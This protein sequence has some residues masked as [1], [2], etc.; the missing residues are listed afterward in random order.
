MEK[1]VTKK[2]HTNKEKLMLLYKRNILVSSKER[3]KSKFIK[4]IEII[5]LP[6]PNKS[7][8]GNCI[9]TRTA[10]SLQ[11]LIY[12]VFISSQQS[13]PNAPLRPYVLDQ[14][15]LHKQLHEQQ[16]N[17]GAHMILITL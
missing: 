4:I 17:K 3:E 14:R 11:P 16:G 5:P 2:L 6:K 1:L 8:L 9:V 12:Q 10:L 13:P 15:L 7:A